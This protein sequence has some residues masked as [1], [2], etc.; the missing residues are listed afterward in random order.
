MREFRLRADATFYARNIDEAL[1]YLRSYFEA[2]QYDLER[3][4][5]LVSGEIRVEPASLADLGEE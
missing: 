3:P 1:E 5:H 4:T 2:I